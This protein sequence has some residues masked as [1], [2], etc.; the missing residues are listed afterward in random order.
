LRPGLP[1]DEARLAK[2]LGRDALQ[3]A[4]DR[5]LHFLETRPR[6]ERE[7]RTR[8]TQAGV[9]PELLDKVVERLNGLG[10]IDDAAFARYWIDNRERFSP[11][12]TRMIKAE[13]FQKGL[14]SEVIAE[15]IEGAIDEEAGARGIA[16]RQ[17][18]RW[19]KLDRNLFRQKMWSLLS[20]KG[21]GYDVIQPVVEEAW[22][23]VAA[24]PGDDDEDGERES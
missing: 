20:R 23:A 17:A 5:A 12:G 4:V 3:D 9:S 15:Q 16:L 22:L 10:L 6:S 13:L 2:L 24:D 8:L 14:K 18:P 7:V 11:R 1:F 21:F 19:A